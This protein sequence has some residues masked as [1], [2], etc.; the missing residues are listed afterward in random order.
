LIAAF[1]PADTLSPVVAF[2]SPK[3][4]KASIVATVASNPP[5]ALPNLPARLLKDRS[6]LAVE[7]AEPF[8]TKSSVPFA[9]AV[10]PLCPRSP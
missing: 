1:V 10:S 5:L 4:F 8:I 9:T 7:T 2:G 6:D 3:V